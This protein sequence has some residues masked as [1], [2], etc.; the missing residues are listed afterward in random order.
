L[1]GKGFISLAFKRIVT[2]AQRMKP[3]REAKR[4]AL[5]V[6]TSGFSYKEWKGPFYPE[7]LPVKRMLAYYAQRFRAVEINST[8]YGLPSPSSLENWAGEVPEGFRF[9]LKAPQQITHRKRLKD[10]G[11]PLSR[12]VQ[13]AGA[14]GA[15]LGPLL[16]QLPPTMRKD[17]A[18][19]GDFLSLM[20][21]DVPAAFE[22][23][24]ESWFDDEIFGLL[25]RHRAALCIAEAEEGPSAPLTATAD[26][27]YLRLRRAEYGEADLAAWAERLHDLGWRD[28]YV[29]FKHEEAGRGTGYAERFVELAAGKAA[30]NREGA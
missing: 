23:R 20:P 26:W 14:L 9:A 18:R 13:A 16:F 3:S 25:S 7:D 29:F 5:Y 8:F 10:S 22:F 27:G 19:L 17:N 21:S 2:L 28:A 12:L 1:Q 15:R 24:H 11:E 4:M 6:G 30:L